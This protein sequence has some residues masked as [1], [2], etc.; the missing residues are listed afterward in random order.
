LQN[1]KKQF[2][3]KFGESEI[4]LSI[5]LD[6]EF[7]IVYNESGYHNILPDDSFI[8]HIVLNKRN[9]SPDV[10][11]NAIDIHFN[12]K[13]IDAYR[14]N[15]YK[16]VLDK[17][18]LPKT[19]D[20]WNNLPETMSFITEIVFTDGKQKILLNGGGGSTAANLIG[21]FTIGDPEIRNYAEQISAVDKKINE[22]VILAEIVHLS[23]ARVGNI[24]S[25]S[26]LY[27]YEIPYL[28][29]STK[30]ADN[31]IPISD[32][33]I[34]IN[35]TGNIVLRSISKNKKVIPRLTNAHNYGVNS[36]PIY[37]FLC[38]LQLEDKRKAIRLDLG[39]VSK[40]YKFIPRIEYKNIIFSKA[41]WNF[42]K[43][44]LI[45]LFKTDYY[46][47]LKSNIKNLRTEWKIPRYINLIEGD[48]ELLIDLENKRSIY[49]MLDVI[50]KK[51]KIS[52][53]EFL[54]YDE[55]QVVK[56]GDSNFTNQVII[57]IYKNHTN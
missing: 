45:P 29:K 9:L 43:E 31:Q 17:D 25:R 33:V 51:E 34:S 28:A 3:E 37:L 21:R 2:I 36:T 47:N 57:S 38:D 52:F 5:A 11:L 41:I 46:E 44:D 26:S 24:T 32:L 7:G 4:P 19:N 20:N 8:N 14:K 10:R 35:N 50:S 55:N 6:S 56:R 27:D 53:E 22:D 39:N 30:K 15:E 12:Q 13:I 48:N 54:F 1:F 49:V 42:T 18:K 16:I 23:E 40:L